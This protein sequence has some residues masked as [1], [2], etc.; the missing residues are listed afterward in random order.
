MKPEADGSMFSPLGEAGTASI[1][2]EIGDAAIDMGLE[3]QKYESQQKELR[4]QWMSKVES[5]KPDSASFSSTADLIQYVKI[6]LAGSLRTINIV[7]VQVFDE[8]DTNIA[9]KSSG[10]TASQS[11]TYNWDG[12]DCV[13]DIAIDGSTSISDTE[14]C[15][16][17]SHTLEDQDPWWMVDLGS[18]HQVS[19]VVIHNRLADCGPC[20][21]KL[22]H[23]TVWLLNENKAPIRKV[24][25]IGDTTGLEEISLDA[26]SFSLEIQD[27]DMMC[28]NS[29]LIEKMVASGLESL[30][31]KSDLSR[32]LQTT[33]FSALVDEANF[34]ARDTK[35][36]QH[37]MAEIS[38]RKVEYEK[39]Q[40]QPPPST[41]KFNRKSL[42]YLVDGPLLQRGITGWINCLVDFI[43]GY[44]DT[45]DALLDW[46]VG[47]SRSTFAE[48]IV[49]AFLR[50]I[51]LIPF[52]DQF[53]E[54]FKSAG[55]L[56]GRT[57]TLLEE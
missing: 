11:S 49:D 31:K 27:D 25:D 36:L 57:R 4:H 37:D 34:E 5:S 33:L 35:A 17:L 10:A 8:T 21:S 20:S 26:N 32:E 28:A 1:N 54:H 24:P 42:H 30:R 44:N 50:V 39:R 51:R 6:S 2:K 12:H 13:A 9:L 16:G 48:I 7:E 38:L 46:V 53:A 29:N 15:H 45:V 23:A 47:D 43:S 52:N 41:K 14:I 19:K 56:A 3:R 18:A 55:I 22:S 40:Q